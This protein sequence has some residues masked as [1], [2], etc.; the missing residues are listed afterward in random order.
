[1]D[2]KDNRKLDG[3]T[4]EENLPD[5]IHSKNRLGRSTD[6]KNST[7]CRTKPMSK[8][9]FYSIYRPPEVGCQLVTVRWLSVGNKRLRSLILEP[10][11]LEA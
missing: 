11:S 5:K 6:K 1:M 3:Q 2:Q 4:Q 9:Y 7:S 8:Q 10:S